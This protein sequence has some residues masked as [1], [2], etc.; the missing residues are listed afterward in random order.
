[1]DP[2]EQKRNNEDPIDVLVH[3]VRDRLDDDG[4]NVDLALIDDYID[5]V[6]EPNDHAEVEKRV[7]TW[8]NWHD[9]Y[10]EARAFTYCDLDD[11]TKVRSS[12]PRS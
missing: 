12:D 8:R 2:F 3:R 11:P 6:L 4:P 9:A 1:M 10:W 5:K 7:R